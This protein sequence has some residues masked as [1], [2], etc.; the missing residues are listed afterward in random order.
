[1]TVKIINKGTC[2]S[3]ASVNPTRKNSVTS[4][5]FSIKVIWE[6]PW[7]VPTT[8]RKILMLVE[9]H[10]EIQSVTSAFAHISSSCPVQEFVKEAGLDSGGGH[11]MSEVIHL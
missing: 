4:E 11:G 6:L 9:H 7:Q 3:R 2:S 1:M 8:R 5:I 10:H